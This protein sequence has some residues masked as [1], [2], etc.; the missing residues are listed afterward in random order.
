MSDPEPR[1][2]PTPREMLELVLLFFTASSGRDFARWEELL[3]DVEPKREALIEIVRQVLEATPILAS[4]VDA[5]DLMR[6]A[7]ADGFATHVM[8]FGREHRGMQTRMQVRTVHNADNLA[9][10]AEAL[11]LALERLGHH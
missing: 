8:V 1:P 3:P 6:A 10:L 7:E 11:W 4:D 2:L 5:E 9:D